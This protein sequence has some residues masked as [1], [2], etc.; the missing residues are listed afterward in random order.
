M[1]RKWLSQI[2]HVNKK[3]KRSF[4]HPFSKWSVITRGTM[5]QILNHGLISKLLCS[6]QDHIWW[7]PKVLL[8]RVGL[9]PF[10]FW[11]R[12]HTFWVDAWIEDLAIFLIFP[13][14][15]FLQLVFCFVVEYVLC[16]LFQLCWRYFCWIKINMNWMINKVAI[17][18]IKVD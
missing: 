18:P 10:W 13:F 7:K 8:I 9:G 14:P 12:Y 6:V 2:E 5:C 3:Q 1:P 15:G 11:S 4:L 17:I 16:D